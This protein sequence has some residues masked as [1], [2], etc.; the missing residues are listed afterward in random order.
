MTS[1][2]NAGTPGSADGLGDL[3]SVAAIAAEAATVDG[4]EPLDEAT[5]MALRHPEAHGADLTTTDAGFT[6]VL[7]GALSL[8][9]R[10][11]ARAQ[12]HGGRLLG[13]VLRRQNGPLTAWSHADHPAARRLAERHCFARTRELWVM[14]RPAADLP[15]L[16]VPEGVA[17]RGYTDADV[18]EIVRVN[19]AAFA[20]HPE[21]GAMDRTGFKARAGENRTAYDDLIV[22]EEDG[23]LLGFHWTKRHSATLGEVYVVGVAP[24][25]QG[26]GLGK[27]LTLAGLHHL[28]A[29]GATDLLL[30]VE[31]DNAPAIATY[32]RLGFTHQPA[33]THVQYSRS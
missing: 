5:W 32:S 24:E 19:A 7:D 10:P 6:L 23:R 29:G 3:S 8:V 27:V 26:R 25:A 13:D 20:S 1:P 15:G 9:V 2:T 28:A 16:D 30:Y 17:I 4:A 22:A 14:R 11:R 12:G 31:G 18:D 21:Q 33:D